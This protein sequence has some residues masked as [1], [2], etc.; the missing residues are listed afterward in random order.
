MINDRADWEKHVDKAAKKFEDQVFKAV[1]QF[2]GST[3]SYEAA[4]V[5]ARAYALLVKEDD[6]KTA[7]SRIFTQD[8]LASKN[9]KET[10]GAK[11]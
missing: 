1:Y 5:L 8:F 11:P 6:I 3:S 2:K 9:S 10:T 7:E 4:D